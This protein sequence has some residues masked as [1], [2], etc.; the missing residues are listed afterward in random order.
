MI[1]IEDL[2]LLPIGSQGQKSR[3]GVYTCPICGKYFTSKVSHINNGKVTKC[4][5]CAIDILLD[6]NKVKSLEAKTTILSRFAEIHGNTYDY[7][8]VDYVNSKTNIKILCKIHGVFKQSPSNHLA[9]K[10]CPECA[11]QAL[12]GYSNNY[13]S[14]SIHKVYFVYIPVVKMWKIGVTREETTSSRFRK[15][16]TEVNILHEFVFSNGKLAYDFE[17]LCLNTFIQSRYMTQNTPKSKVL[18]DGNYEL[19]I[20]DILEDIIKLY[21]EV[22]SV[23]KDVK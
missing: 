9:G 20:V 18:P 17:L 5:N 14:I 6:N 12:T 10:G 3:Y 8:V 13:N 19:F 15:W 16:K 11:I 21:K 7:S 1:L 23:L 22:N 2:G 4:K